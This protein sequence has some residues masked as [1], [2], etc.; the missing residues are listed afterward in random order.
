VTAE[1]RTELNAADAKAISQFVEK[2]FAG[3]DVDRLMLATTRELV[4][5]G[6]PSHVLRGLSQLGAI[7]AIHKETENCADEK[8][9]ALLRAA[10]ALVRADTPPEQ[11]FPLVELYRDLRGGSGKKRR[12]LGL[13]TALATFSAAVTMLKK[14]RTVEAVIAEIATPNGISRKELK[15]FRNRLN[16]GL[17]PPGAVSAYQHALAYMEGMNK[18]ELMNHLAQVS[19]RFCT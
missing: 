13:R 16:R 4:K 2:A 1:R 14:G 8:R 12:K 19:K 5:A 7:I 15:N 9:L 17:A 10:L 11:I 18:T 3:G 6:A